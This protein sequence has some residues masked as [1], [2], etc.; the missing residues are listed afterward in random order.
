MPE[1]SPHTQH[2]WRILITLS[3]AFSLVTLAGGYIYFRTQEQHVSREKYTEISAIAGLKE[4]QIRQWRMERLAAVGRPAGSPFFR[5]IVKEWRDSGFSSSHRNALRDRLKMEC[6]RGFEDAL[7]FSPDGAILLSAK[8]DPDPPDPATKRALESAAKGEAALSD[9]FRCPNGRIHIDAVAPVRDDD[10]AV[11]AILAQR[12]DASSYL[13]PLIRSRPIPSKSSETMLVQRRGDQVLYLNEPRQRTGTPL[14]LRLPLSRTDAPAVAAVLGTKGLFRGRDYRGEKVLADLRPIGGSPWFLVAKIDEREIRAEARKQALLVTLA[15]LCFILIASVT[16]AYVYRRRESGM[17]RELYR[18]EQEQR[19]A[20]E[21]LRESEELV[22][23]K[24]DALLLPDGDLGKLELEDIIDVREI[25]KLMEDFFAMENMVTAIVDIHG[26][27]LVATGWQDI[28]VKFHRVHPETLANCRQSDTVLSSGIAPGAFRIYKC[29]NNLWDLATPIIVDGRHVGNFFSG[30]FI[31]EDEA[32][33]Y[34]LFRAQAQRY[35]FD[36]KEYLA[37]LERVP[38]WNREK[39]ERVMTFFARF[40]RLLSDLSFA[41]IR[42]ARTLAEHEKMEAQFLQAQKMEAVGRLAGGV[43]HDF[44]NMLNVML[45]YAEMAL[46][47]LEPGTKLHNYITEITRAGRR[48]ADLTRQL[49][50]FARKQTIA[51]RVLDLNDT[52][53]SMLKMLKRM[54]GENIELTWKPADRMWQVNM[55]PAQVDQI[56]VNLVVNARDAIAGVGRITIETGKA[57]FDE[58]YQDLHPE[59]IPGRY[60]QLVV[61]DD[62]CGMDGK[63]RA[64][65]FEPFFTTK[66]VGKGTGLGLATVYGIVSQNSGFINVYSEPGKGSTFRIYLPR[67]EPAKKEPDEAVDQAPVPAGAETVLLVEDEDSLLSLG[68]ILLEE[69]GYKVLAAAGP[70]DALRIVDEYEGEIHLVFTDVI[71]PEMSGNELHDRLIISRP[72]LKSLFM[73]G[74]TADIITRHGVL[75]E[76]VHFLQKPFSVQDL[77]I[78]L[79]EA[80]DG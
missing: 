63:T 2:S 35:G 79:R 30:Q 29:K 43:A 11:I 33:D 65:L 73:S 32:P 3:L 8:G 19:K 27:V 75:H 21:A 78:K 26:K 49:L 71:M 12:S 48:S 24:L 31:L 72:G 22:R 46:T 41:N 60:A 37:A 68:T 9:F 25:K 80:L 4:W 51:P 14:S 45:G 47:R 34:E 54:I 13:Y 23:M 20:E 69:L 52:I 5:K 66:E 1:A 58:A 61:S 62:G 36:E 67:H 50:A 59:F 17:Y 38:R 7:L 55:D 56:L 42:L 28:C 64:M 6:T 44:N 76:G 18:V 39:I 15:G 16:T 53:E 40:S 10:G 77:A 57:E 74:Y 70:R